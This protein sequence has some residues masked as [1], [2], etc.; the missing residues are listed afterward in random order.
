MVYNQIDF[1]ICGQRE[2]RR[3]YN[4]QSRVKTEMQ[5]DHRLVCAYLEDEGDNWRRKTQSKRDER[6][7]PNGRVPDYDR[8]VLA[9]AEV[10]AEWKRRIKEKM[11]EWEEKGGEKRW[12][13]LKDTMAEVAQELFPKKEARKWRPRRFRDNI[14]IVRL[15]KAQQRMR[16]RMESA[17]TPE[18]ASEWRAKRRRVLREL[19]AECG[20]QAR[21]WI[22]EEVLE[23]ERWRS[24]ARK[25]HNALKRARRRKNTFGIKVRSKEGVMLQHPRDKMPYVMEYFGD[26]FGAAATPTVEEPERGPLKRP[27]T[28]REVAVALAAIA[29]GK[30]AGADGVPGEWLKYV[31]SPEFNEEL[32]RV[33]N[34]WLE[35]GREAV[36]GT[37]VLVPLQ[38]PSKE[39]GPV[40]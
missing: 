15:S 27:I 1:V 39:H 30:A 8:S 10:R 32:A 25:M 35:E 14:H 12:Q 23:V 20:K 17:K 29:N 34:S 31:A 38:K 21:A 4:A 18:K 33:L 5:S 13:R 36:V 3:V 16:D 26:V 28:A 7:E 9:N 19:K 24:D 22:E 40:S 37:G 11:A 6:N 2:A